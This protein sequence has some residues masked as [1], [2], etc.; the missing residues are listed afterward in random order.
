ME[1]WRA[2]RE[3][4][5]EAINPVMHEPIL[6]PRM[7]PIAPSSVITW[8]MPI[9][10]AMLVTAVLLCVM[11]VIT[12]P[13]EHAHEGVLA[14]LHQQLGDPG[15]LHQVIERGGHVAHPDE[16]QP[17]AHQDLAVFF[18]IPVREILH[19]R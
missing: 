10:T 8:L 17:Q 12:R 11:E 4:R 5:M 13:G 18:P 2:E 9:A 6:A 3:S 1:A 7:M 19:E 16:D 15:D 14:H